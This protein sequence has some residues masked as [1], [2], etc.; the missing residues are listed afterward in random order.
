MQNESGISPEKALEAAEKMQ[1]LA[2]FPF[3]GGVV[4][5]ALAEMLSQCLETDAQAQKF[6]DAALK[7]DKYP[8]PGTLRAMALEAAG[9]SAQ[10]IPEYRRPE[11]GDAVLCPRCRNTGW[12]L[13]RIPCD[14]CR[15][16]GCRLCVGRGFYTEP[17]MCS[18]EFGD[19]QRAQAEYRARPTASTTVVMPPVVLPPLPAEQ[20]I[21]EAD[22]AALIPETKP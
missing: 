18:C 19:A 7:L 15:G 10:A 13:T 12:R 20:R 21:T 2:D 22:F 5:A 8:G 6:L 16:S 1:A 9:A 3:G 11:V 14:S 17:V 4:V